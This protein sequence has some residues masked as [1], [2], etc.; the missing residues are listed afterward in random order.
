MNIYL[1][2]GLSLALT[3]FIEGILTEIGRRPLLPVLAANLLT[4]PPL[5]LLW[6]MLGQNP[7]LFILSELAAFAIEGGCYRLLGL[8]KPFR[9]SLLCNGI[10]CMF[11]I[12]LGGI[13]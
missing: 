7:I 9:F 3:L 10:S 13:L 6:M 8:H 11:G 2:L 1:T 4:N 5:V 12:I